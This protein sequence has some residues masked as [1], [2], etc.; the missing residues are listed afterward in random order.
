MA[1]AN[2]REIYY[3]LEKPSA[4]DWNK[5]QTELDFTTRNNAR[6]QFASRAT[7]SPG[8]DANIAPT[9]LFADAFKIRPT[10]PASLAVVVSAGI[11]YQDR[12]TETVDIDGVSG[13]SDLGR[14]KPLVLSEDVVFQVPA[15]S[16]SLRIDIIEVKAEYLVNNLQQRERLNVLTRVF[17][18][19]VLNKSLIWDLK[20]RRGQGAGAATAPLY[21][22]VGTSGGPAPS[23]DAGYIQL[24]R[25]VVSPVAT[26]IGA[27]HIVDDRI[28]LAPGGYLDV[29]A[30]VTLYV[31]DTPGALNIAA[32]PPGVKMGFV[33]NGA[34]VG[35]R[36]GGTWIIAAG[37]LPTLAMPG[38]MTRF[39]VVAPQDYSGGDFGWNQV[40]TEPLDA[41]YQGYLLD[42]A[43][44]STPLELAVGQPIVRMS[45]NTSKDSYSDDTPLR[46]FVGARLKW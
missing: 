26:S 20:D 2:E 39:G 41:T 6:Y 35:A 25:V 36:G 31:N 11:G 44:T 13:L 8:G 23:I 43:Y 5:M 33:S 24:G 19:T 16:A 22:K 3:G 14:S 18:P 21:Y 29:K 32:C 30:E 4:T 7:F 27:D 17:D 40:F 34:A 38:E 12:L 42:P 45:L 1:G 46:F 15:P 9:G 28:P 37:A 10:S